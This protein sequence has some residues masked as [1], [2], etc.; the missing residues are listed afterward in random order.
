[1]NAQMEF[2]QILDELEEAER[3]ALDAHRTK[4]QTWF[5]ALTPRQKDE[6]GEMK[7][8]NLDLT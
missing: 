3:L 7:C 8:R 1:M 5:D 4:V 2:E 6:L